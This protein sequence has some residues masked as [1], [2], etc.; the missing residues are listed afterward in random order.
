MSRVEL[1]DSSKQQ[2]LGYLLAPVVLLGGS[3]RRLTSGF[4]SN[5][6]RGGIGCLQCRRL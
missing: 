3:T 1:G 6:P 2:F 4:A 5:R